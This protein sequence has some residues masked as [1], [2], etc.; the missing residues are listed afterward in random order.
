MRKAGK[1]PGDVHQ[2]VYTLEYGEA[3]LEVHKEDI[4]AGM[5]VLIIDDVLA[6]GGTALAAAQLVERANAEVVGFGFVLDLEF[7]GGREKLKSYTI[8]SLKTITG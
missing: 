5:R 8:H 7:L 3:T 6:T 4:K 1:L 2:A